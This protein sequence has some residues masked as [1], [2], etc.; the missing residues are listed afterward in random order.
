MQFTQESD[1]LIKNLKTKYGQ[2]L[3]MKTLKAV[4]RAGGADPNLKRLVKIR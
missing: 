3:P 2:I 1:I 4:L